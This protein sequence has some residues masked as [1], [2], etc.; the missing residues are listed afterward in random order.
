MESLEAALAKDLAW[1]KKEIVGLRNSARQSDDQ[2]TYLFRA[3]LVLLCAHWEGFLKK[4]IDSYIDHVFA[5]SL[6]VKD[7]IP[8][9]V[10]ISFYGDARAASVA[11]YP[12]SELS[13]LRLAQRIAL[14]SEVSCVERTWQASTEG[15][16][17]SEVLGRLLRSAGLDLQL[18][19]DDATWSTMKVFIDEQIVRDR[20]LIA[21]GEGLPLNKT[22]FLARAQRTVRILD[23]LSDLVIQS[24]QA[25]AYKAA[26]TTE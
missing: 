24:A 21:H 15:N 23:I 25:E 18:A 12:G 9:F 3:G 22:D 20:H 6:R 13:H 14:G 7:L 11:A 16:P 5:Q 17:G 2:R 4:A 26:A 1:R 10:A 19:M 8:N